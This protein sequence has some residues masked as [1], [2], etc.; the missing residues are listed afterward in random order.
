MPALYGLLVRFLRLV[1]AVFFRRIEVV[2]LEHV[3]TQGP[4]IFVGNH[5]NSL[6]DPVLITT[7]CGRQVHFLAKDTLFE[8]RFLGLF[9]RTLGAVPVKR[10]HDHAEAHASG[11]LD[12]DAAF[13]ALFEVLRAGRACGVFPEGISHAGSE[14]APLRTGAARIAFGAARSAEGAPVPVAV[15]PCG[16]TYHRR[17]RMRGRV[18]VQ[19]GAPLTIDAAR[20]AAWQADE[21]AA[22]RALTDEI[23]VALRALT[24]NAP[25]FETLRVLDAVRRLYT[26]SGHPLTLA[27]QA[28]LTRRFVGR[29]LELQEEPEVRALYGR[30]A[31][32]Q[33]RLDA[34][35]LR[36]D[37]LDQAV[38]PGR[39]LGRVLRHWTLLF[40]LAPLALPGLLLHAPVLA[41]AVVAGDGL[42]SRKDVIATTKVMT[43]TLLVPLGYAL[44]VLALALLVP[45]G[46]RLWAT[47]TAAVLLPLSGWATIRVLERQAALRRALWSLA[48]LFV[49]RRAVERLRRE[50]EEV[51]RAIATA[52]ERFVPPELDRIIPPEASAGVE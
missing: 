23:E 18:L 47:G 7:T 9:L 48:T 49:L 43:L 13:A 50:R 39:W 38:S 27:Q 14:L 41:A 22:V 29:Y 46:E 17:T 51:S 8:S 5:P 31:E 26:P 4:V 1:T 52:V 6:L 37:D 20:L 45:R 2:G 15:V 34:L 42:T 21:R 19:Y 40:V 35:G 30:V 16:L 33:A 12:N 32:L 44:T 28:E 24:I 3:P 25:D 10:R 36:D 11:Q